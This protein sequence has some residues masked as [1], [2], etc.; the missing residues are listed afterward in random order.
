MADLSLAAAPNSRLYNAICTED[1]PGVWFVSIPEVPGCHSQVATRREA[2]E[3]I[4]EAL[5]VSDNDVFSG[6]VVAVIVE[7]ERGRI[8]SREGPTAE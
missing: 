7:T 5:A 6:T 8:R 2:M 4:H 3:R 1:A